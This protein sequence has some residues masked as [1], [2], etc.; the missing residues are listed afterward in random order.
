M[1]LTI[2]SSFIWLQETKDKTQQTR[3]V[4]QAGWCIPA[5]CT[6]QDL[7]KSLNKY[8]NIVEHPLLNENVTYSASISKEACQTDIGRRHMDGADIGFW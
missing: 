3:H 2:I 1:V 8:L 7:E 5:S 4:I 6:P